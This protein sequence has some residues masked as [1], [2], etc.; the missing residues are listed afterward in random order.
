MSH[1]ET[2]TLTLPCLS[3]YNCGNGIDARRISTENACIDF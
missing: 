1:A 2:G 3:C